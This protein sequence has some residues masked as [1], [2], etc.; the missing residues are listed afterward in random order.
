M[1]KSSKLGW[2][3]ICI[4]LIKRSVGASSIIGRRYFFSTYLFISDSIHAGLCLESE[5]G[6]GT[7]KAQAYKCGMSQK[8]N[9]ERGNSFSLCRCLIAS[10]PYILIEGKVSL[11]KNCSRID[12]QVVYLGSKL[13][14]GFSSGQN[15][16]F[17][18][19]KSMQCSIQ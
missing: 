6:S 15:F 3:I 7:C 5:G 10:F 14:S 12:K 9:C 2:S 19:R 16:Q 18:E 4:Y 13:E 8:Q 17:I 11:R 1:R